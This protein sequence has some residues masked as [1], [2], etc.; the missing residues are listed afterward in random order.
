V[1]DLVSEKV[2]QFV[3]FKILNQMRSLTNI[4]FG[5]EL[6]VQ[7]QLSSNGRRVMETSASNQGYAG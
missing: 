1:I 7:S 3:P 6:M 4:G 2:L 5:V